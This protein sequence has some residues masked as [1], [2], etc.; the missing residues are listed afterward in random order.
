[1]SII[2]T[3]QVV[4]YLIITLIIGYRSGR[5]VKTM[6]EFSVGGK[7]LPTA[8]LV[9]TILYCRYHFFSN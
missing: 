7:T 8:A 9:A 2:D 1:M 3:I 6:Q 4:I 5:Y